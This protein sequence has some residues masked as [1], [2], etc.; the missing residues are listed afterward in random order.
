MTRLL[1]LISLVLAASAGSA[2][3]KKPQLIMFEQWGCEWCEVWMEEIGPVLPKTR[4]GR[5]TT[6][7]RL[8]IHESDSELLKK[9]KPVV[10]TPTFVVFEDGEE[11]G[12]VVG[13]AGED[14][15]WHQL[16]SHLKKLKRKCE[17]TS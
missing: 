6:F 13:Y 3:A 14:F 5:C 8:D 10:F 15:F 9:I 4:E 11:V 7:S 16:S 2:V 1:A 17:P 12:R